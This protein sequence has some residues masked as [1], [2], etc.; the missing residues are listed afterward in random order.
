M[1]LLRGKTIQPGRSYSDPSTLFISN[2]IYGSGYG[3]VPSVEDELKG[4]KLTGTLPAPDMVSKMFSELEA[5]VSYADRAKKTY[6]RS[7][8]R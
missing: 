7:L 8:F 1:E 4:F 2:T 5:G 6:P 3:K